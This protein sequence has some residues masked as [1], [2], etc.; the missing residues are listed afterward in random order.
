M[1]G[2]LAN[3]GHEVAR[4]AIANMLKERG[5]EPAPARSRK[6]TWKEFLSRHWEVMVAMDFFTAEVWTRSGLTRFI[7]LFLIDLSTRR[8]EIA[9][10]ATKA[11]GIWMG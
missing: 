10:I 1:Q 7:V 6:T 11:D 5:L 8:V 4:G 3:P 9:G 2:A